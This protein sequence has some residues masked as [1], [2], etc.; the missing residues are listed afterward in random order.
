VAVAVDPARDGFVAVRSGE[1]V[2]KFPGRT[3]RLPVWISAK[4]SSNFRDAALCVVTVLVFEGVLM[5]V[6]VTRRIAALNVGLGAEKGRNVTLLSLLC[7]SL[8]LSIVAGRQ[9]AG[10]GIMFIEGSLLNPDWFPQPTPRRL[11]AVRW[12][13]G[14]V[15]LLGLIDPT[16]IEFASVLF[17]IFG[18]LQIMLPTALILRSSLAAAAKFLLLSLFLSATLIASNFI[19]SESL[20]LLALTTISSFIL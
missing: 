15:R 1:A 10:D 16:Q 7:C 13:T 18:C 8:A 19:V 17:G 3:K 2:R 11:F 12:T 5:P 4:N 9:L 6:R 20:F 14:A